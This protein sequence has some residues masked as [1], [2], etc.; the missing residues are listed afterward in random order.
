MART[1][2]H[3]YTA[4][5]AKRIHT[6]SGIGMN[7]DQIARIENLSESTLK[8]LYQKEL[9][10]GREAAI[11]NVS[12][13]AYQMAMSG[14]VPAMT[15]FWL[16]TRARWREV[17]AIEHS[18]PDGKPIETKQTEPTKE[19]LKRMAEEIVNGK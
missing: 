1:K 16:K 17:H 14:K 8:R 7:I 4:E 3:I 19:Q 12:K 10:E 9:T 2:E 13:T 11:S 15:M 6:L 18:G 5:Q